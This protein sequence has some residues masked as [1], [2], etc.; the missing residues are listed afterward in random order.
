MIG[1]DILFFVFAPKF[2]FDPEVCSLEKTH[3]QEH[4]IC[5]RILIEFLIVGIRSAYEVILNLLLDQPNLETYCGPSY[6]H[7]LQEI[8]RRQLCN[9]T[10]F[11]QFCFHLAHQSSLASDQCVRRALRVPQTRAREGVEVIREGCVPEASS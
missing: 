3:A 5:F 6:F 4:T 10:F 11:A 9:R 1:S 7:K 2:L 8:G